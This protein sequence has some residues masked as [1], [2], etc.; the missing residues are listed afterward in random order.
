MKKDSIILKVIL[1]EIKEKSNSIDT[2][3]QYFLWNNK[4]FSQ[5]MKTKCGDDFKETNWENLN[6]CNVYC[7]FIWKEY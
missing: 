2:M 3:K 7:G 4:V 1:N 5:L 6:D